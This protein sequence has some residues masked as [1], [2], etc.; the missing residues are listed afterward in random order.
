MTRLTYAWELAPKLVEDPCCKE[1]RLAAKFMHVARRNGVIDPK[2]PSV[3]TPNEAYLTHTDLQTGYRAICL[4]L[5]PE[6][7]KRALAKFE[8]AALLAPRAPSEDVRVEPQIQMA[9]SVPSNK[10]VMGG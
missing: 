8:A 7:V 4:T 3:S 6:L 5:P 2:A 9:A 10:M 1:S